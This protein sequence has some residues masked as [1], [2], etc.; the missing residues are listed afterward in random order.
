[1]ILSKDTNPKRDVYFIGS[2]I[3][4]LMNEQEVQEYEFLEL[5]LKFKATNK[6]SIN[7]FSQAIIWLFLLGAVSYSDKGNIIK[8]F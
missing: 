3:L 4:S 2:Q 8:C 1:M 5:Y 7:L 6:L